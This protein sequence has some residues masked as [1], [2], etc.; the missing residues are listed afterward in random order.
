VDYN[1]ERLQLN[2]SLGWYFSKICDDFLPYTF[3]SLTSPPVSSH[4]SNAVAI[5][6]G[7]TLGVVFLLAAAVVV[8][9]Q[10]EFTSTFKHSELCVDCLP[11]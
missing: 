6:V 10:P 1:R 2:H 7:V 5:S 11:K 8:G 4:H 9:I 3:V